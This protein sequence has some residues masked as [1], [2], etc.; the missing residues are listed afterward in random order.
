ME[1]YE[2]AFEEI[3][4][5]H[6]VPAVVVSIAYYEARKHKEKVDGQVPVVDDLFYVIAS[7]KSLENV[8]YD[9][10]DCGYT[11][12]S[13]E[14]FVMAFGIGEDGRLRLQ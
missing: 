14:D 6:L 4:Q 11:A 7:R 3:F 9:Y 1:A 5:R 10:H 12:Q 13:V 8:E 2:A